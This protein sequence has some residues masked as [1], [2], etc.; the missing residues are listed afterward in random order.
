MWETRSRASTDILDNI[1]K[2]SDK[3]LK[4]SSNPDVYVPTDNWWSNPKA[5][6]KANA[7]KDH[8]S[9]AYYQLSKEPLIAAVL[10]ETEDGERRVYYFSRRIQAP[11][12]PKKVISPT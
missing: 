4:K 2:I 6:K 7:T 11:D 10:V 5:V 3:A 1:N 9:K 12:M 8:Y